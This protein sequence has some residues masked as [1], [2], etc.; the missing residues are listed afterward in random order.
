M[1]I[2]TNLLCVCT[3]QY[4]PRK[5]L[6]YML[7]SA[8]QLLDS[9]GKEEDPPSRGRSFRGGGPRPEAPVNLRTAVIH[10]ISWD[11]AKTPR[12]SSKLAVLGSTSS[13][14]NPDPE[15]GCPQALSTR[16]I[17]VLLPL[18]RRGLGTFTSRMSS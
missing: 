6:L 2:P 7:L 17:H 14:F 18:T 8:F 4:I 1:Y 10:R 12:T 15:H 5:A 16:T 3:C 11:A 9:A 13:S